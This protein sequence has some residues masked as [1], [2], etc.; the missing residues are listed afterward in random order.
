M[1]IK[2]NKFEYFIIFDVKKILFMTNRHLYAAARR[3]ARHNPTDVG[4]AATKTSVAQNKNF[5]TTRADSAIINGVKCLKL[6]T[7]ALAAVTAATIFGFGGAVSASAAEETV[8][9]DD[10]TCTLEISDGITDYAIDRDALAIASRTAI[11]LLTTDEVGDRKLTTVIHESEID[12]IDYSDGELYIR[13]TYGN[14]YKYPD[15]T[16]Q[17]VHEFTE[18]NLWKVDFG[19]MTYI[20]NTATG[21]LTC[22]QNGTPAIIGEEGFSLMKMFG[23]NLYAVCDGVPYRI[24]GTSATALSLDYVDY[25]SA[26][27]IY[28][29]DALATLKSSSYTVKTA[30]LKS[31]EYYTK[32]DTSAISEYFTQVQTYKAN[33]EK[34]CLVLAESGNASVVAMNDGCYIAKTE[35]LSVIAYSAPA[36]DWT[37]GAD[38]KRKA[39]IRE[40]VG[41]YA[42]PYMCDATKIDLL[43]R[44]DVVEVTEKFALD[45]IDKVFYRVTYTAS[46]GSK[47]SGFVAANFLDEY[48]Y[49]ADKLPPS[50]STDEEFTY[51]NEVTTV[52][53]ALVI[54]GLVIIAI[55]YLTIVGTKPQK[56]KGRSDEEE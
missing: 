5:F 45:F 13:N 22:W 46:D 40:S 37:A 19:E 16:A 52:I 6:L 1:H 39:N 49:S 47:K 44:G 38:G 51:E 17:T 4:R 50:S 11:Y 53:L 7:S 55:A 31:G 32:I 23:D 30:V 48:D 9:P 33:G 20:L 10:F 35:S 36:N 24:E 2:Q 29:G 3:R 14:I 42:S 18:N 25:S 12:R 26:D 54:V 15:L 28:T 41:V 43:E 21:E 56:K 34:P 8:Y 27:K